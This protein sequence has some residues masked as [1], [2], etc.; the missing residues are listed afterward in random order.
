[1]PPAPEVTICRKA[2]EFADCLKVRRRVF[3]EEQGVSESDDLDGK[4]TLAIH[5]LAR[6]DG[7]A[8]GTTRIRID[9]NKAE[10]ERVAV[11]REWRKRGIGS[12]LIKALENEAR[13]RGATQFCL[14]AQ[15]HATGF[16]ES[17]GYRKIGN[18][19]MEV[20]IPHVMMHKTE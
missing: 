8:V 19:F 20:G 7:N 15:T 12:A 16:Y 6:I 1:M 11:L 2:S 18:E 13:K 14:S 10:I 9:G 3:I 4:D 17:L 5:A